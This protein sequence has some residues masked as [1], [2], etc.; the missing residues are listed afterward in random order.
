MFHTLFDDFDRRDE[1]KDEDLNAVYS[2]L[3]LILKD[4]GDRPGHEFT[5]HPEWSRVVAHA[6]SALAILAPRVAK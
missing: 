1:I 2:G 4:I 6:K 3:E 5:R